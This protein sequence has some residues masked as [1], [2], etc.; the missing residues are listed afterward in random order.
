MRRTGTS[1]KHQ[2]QSSNDR[3]IPG[4]YPA[5]LSATVTIARRVKGSVKGK[6]TERER[7]TRETRD[8]RE[9]DERDERSI[10][11]T[12]SRNAPLHLTLSLIT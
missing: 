7:E 3:I 6:E 10:C 1:D 5:A 2:T 11:N 9:S 8:E 4:A 12:H